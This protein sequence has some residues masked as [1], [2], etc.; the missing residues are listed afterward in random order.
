M[1]GVAFTFLSFDI[2]WY[3]ILILI[4]V[5]IAFI[6]GRLEFKRHHIDVSLFDDMF[7][8]TVIIGLIGARIWYVLFNLDYYAKDW[9]N[10]FRVWNGGLA[11]HGG[12]IFG[13]IFL[14]FYCRKKKI[15]LFKVMDIV[16]PCLLIGQIIGRWGNFFNQEA[17]GREVALATLNKLHLPQF[18]INGMY[19]EGKYYH[20]TFLYESL[21]NL[22]C[23]IILLILRYNKKIKDGTLLS[24]YLIYYG[25]I[26]F[27]IESLRTDSLML[28]SI[29]I[30]QLISIIFIII[31]I[32][33]LILTRKHERYNGEEK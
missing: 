28:G 22:F 25:I 24:I 1:R 20:P 14:F 31:G 15:S 4:G 12:I 16:A 19:I 33:I 11:I 27:F 17:H 5:I 6:I 18:I 21:A 2:Y 29:R 30:A 10:I 8:Y 13:S 23:L 7:F 32:I 26:R 3:S 9:I